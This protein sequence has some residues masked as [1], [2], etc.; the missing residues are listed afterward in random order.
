M[1]LSKV[2]LQEKNTTRYECSVPVWQSYGFDSTRVTSIG[3]AMETIVNGTF[4]LIV[5]MEEEF[6]LDA[7]NC[8]PL[9]RSM[10][11]AP[12]VI[13]SDYDFDSHYT[14]KAFSLGADE[15]WKTPKNIEEAVAKGNALIRR[16]IDYN[17]NFEC[18]RKT[19]IMNSQVLLSTEDRLVYVQ[20]KQVS[21]FKKEF[22]ILKMLI[23][24]PNRVF[25]YK[26]IY[27]E[28]WGEDYEDNHSNILWS[29]IKSIRKKLK[30]NE[31][32]TEYIRN[33][34]GVGYSFDPH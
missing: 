30:I 20:G 1:N 7:Y 16:A 32:Q 5:L 8:L 2:L 21:L 34:R 4:Q 25:T 3:E 11:Y 10:T 23:S 14:I 19:I 28:V 29:H 33:A 9:L 26:Q 27:T 13:S 18:N 15:V 22:E 6:S 24:A 12:I 17:K 31:D